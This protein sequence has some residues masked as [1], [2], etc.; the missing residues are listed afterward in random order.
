MKSFRLLFTGLVCAS[1]S[2]GYSSSVPSLTAADFDSVVSKTD[3][4]LVK[5]YAPWC[6]H[7]KALAEPYKQAASS[8]A[9]IQHEHS[10]QFGT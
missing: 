3:F 8:V 6:G 7:C 2:A 1:L 5:F 4:T 10:V 9:Q